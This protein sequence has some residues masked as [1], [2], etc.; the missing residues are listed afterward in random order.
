MYDE[1]TF[2]IVILQKSESCVMS[3]FGL[4]ARASENI[5]KSEIPKIQK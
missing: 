2:D 5:K 1:Q 4:M 3:S